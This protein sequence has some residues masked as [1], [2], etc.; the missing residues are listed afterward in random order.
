MSRE[1]DSLSLSLSFRRGRRCLPRVRLVQRRQHVG[2]E[3]VGFRWR[4]GVGHLRLG[5]HVHH[6]LLQRKERISKVL[7]FF[8]QNVFIKF[9]LVFQ[10]G[11]SSFRFSARGALGSRKPG[12]R[13]CAPGGAHLG[14][15]RR[16]RKKEGA[17]NRQRERHRG[18]DRQPRGRYR[19]W[20]MEPEIALHF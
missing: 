11:Y 4:C 18:R 6:L 3:L 19:F 2:L 10:L 20:E 15:G 5:G 13:A 7:N 14:Q 9:F 17:E 1:T 16:R 8:C 12:K